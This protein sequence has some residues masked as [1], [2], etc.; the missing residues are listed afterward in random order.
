MSNKRPLRSY[1][2]WYATL[3]RLYPQ[4]Y[5]ERFGEGMEQTFN[6]ILRERAGQ[7]KGLFGCALWMFLETAVEIFKENMM[8]N[9]NIIR[10]ALA[11][12]FV[13]LI[14]LVAMQFS[15]E[16]NWSVFDFVV[17]GALLFGSGL[18][19]ELIAR[20]GG[21]VAYRAAVGVAVAAALLLVW[22]N[23]A[24]GIIGSENNPVN[25]LYFLV[26]FIGII[27]VGISRL[28][29]RGMAWA[30]FATALAQLLVPVIALLI[31]K[32]QAGA[33]QDPPGFVGVL[34]LNAF[35]AMLFVVSG[36]LFRHASVKAGS[37]AKV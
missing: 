11:T 29:P 31:G 20:K 28:R 15:D 2:K 3:L 36:L 30:L 8:K 32:S 24:V 21:N 33:L 16:V 22:I 26:V 37:E 1:G 4:P 14:P 10:I 5:H 13:L 27:G 35:F 19:Y 18:A 12:A 6:D 7:K 25:A 9:K 23:L 34:A 17:A